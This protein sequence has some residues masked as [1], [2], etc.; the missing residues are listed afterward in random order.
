M[1]KILMTKEKWRA[2]LKKEFKKI[3]KRRVNSSQSSQTN[4]T[5][6]P[7]KTQLLIRTLYPILITCVYR[8]PNETR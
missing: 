8:K 6:S 7:M 5:T 1:M 4:L 2:M 3:Q